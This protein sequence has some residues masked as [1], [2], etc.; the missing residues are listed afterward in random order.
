[1]T[2]PGPESSPILSRTAISVRLS[3][4]YAALFVIIGIRVP[5]LPLWLEGKGLSAPDIA[6]VLALGLAGRLFFTPVAAAIS[7]GREKKRGLLLLLGGGAVAV[8][9]G[10]LVVDG[11]WPILIIMVLSGAFAPAIM[12][13]GESLTMRLAYIRNIDYGR[14]RLWGSVTF[15]LAA[16]LGGPFY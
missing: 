1:M 2:G 11:F 13:L 15:I 6:L 10:L 12:P 9:L 3:F 16:L 4:F 14:V 7:D 8:Y 5:Y